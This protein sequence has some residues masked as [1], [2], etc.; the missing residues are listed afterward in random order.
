[1]RFSG[2]YLHGK[3]RP[4]GDTETH[5]E[6][7]LLGGVRLKCAEVGAGFRH[8]AIHTALKQGW[9]WAWIWEEIE[10]NANIYGPM[11][12]VNIGPEP[13]EP[14]FGWRLSAMRL[15]QDYG[16]LSTIGYDASYYELAAGLSYRFRQLVLEAGYRARRFIYVP[17]RNVRE[18]WYDRSL[19]GGPTAR[20]VLTF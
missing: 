3:F 5:D 14:G 17:A 15:L 1:V 2:A 11:L 16:T 6:L 19:M 12:F 18:E 8:S 7:D 4:P 20:A 13:G 10:R 9:R